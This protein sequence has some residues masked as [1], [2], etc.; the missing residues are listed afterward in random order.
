MYSV[1]LT[2]LKASSAIAS[3]SLLG[4]PATFPA[5]DVLR[6]ILSVADIYLTFY[7]VS[8]GTSENYS[9]NGKTSK[10]TTVH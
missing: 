4:A 6:L 1:L 2:S 10:L 8:Y 9:K 7:A 3:V 5:A